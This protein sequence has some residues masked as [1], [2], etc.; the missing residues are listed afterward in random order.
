M[1]TL[2]ALA[3]PVSLWCCRYC[4]RTSLNF[5]TDSLSTDTQTFLSEGPRGIGDRDRSAWRGT[6]DRHAVEWVIEIA[7]N[8]QMH[9]QLENKV[10]LGFILLWLTVLGPQVAITRAAF[11]TVPSRL[12]IRPC[13]PATR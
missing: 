11:E 4:F 12:E 10:A 13:G 9:E 2:L 8:T 6:P 7:W 3:R 1:L 5:R